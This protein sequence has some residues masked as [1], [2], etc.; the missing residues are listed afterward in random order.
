MKKMLTLIAAALISFP[1]VADQHSAAEAEVRDAVQG[2]NGAYAKNDVERY[3]S[4][5]ADDADMF[6]GGGR[7][8]KSAYHEEWVATISAGGAVEKSDA[9]G[10]QVRVLPGGNSAIASYFIDYR[11]RSPDGEVV[12]EKAFE[13]ET[14][15]KIDGQWKVVGLHY[16]V[17][18]P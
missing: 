10:L 16:T 3:F 11:M 9:S 2:F 17:I 13:S 4:Y 6:W 5:F 15:Q 7:Q 1:A 12:E 8:T 14:W 18:S